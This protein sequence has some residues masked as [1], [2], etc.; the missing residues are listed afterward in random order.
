MAYTTD[1]LVTAIKRDSYLPAA[2]RDFGATNLLA[3]ADEALLETIA[4]A[5]V[6][7]DDG[8]FLEPADAS[9][10]ASTQDYQLDRY[11]MWSKLRRLQMLD[12]GG[13]L[14]TLRR[15][16]SEQAEV[17]DQDGTG[18]PES[19]LML[20]DKI[21]L[22][23]IPTGVETLRQWIYR[24]PG[25][26]VATT[27]AAQVSSVDS[28]TGIVTYTGSKPATF[29]SSSV[30]DFYK[31]SAPF[32]R[33]GTALSATA[34]PGANTQTFSTTNAA[35]LASGDWV[36]VRDETVFPALPVELHSFLK[37]LVIR[38]ITRTQG[39]RQ[40][41]E[42][43]RAEIRDRMIA[44]LQAGPGSRVVGHPKKLSIPLARVYPGLTVR[45]VRG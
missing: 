37:D 44:T 25:R 22:Y 27:A 6:S 28:G 36:C 12:S 13:S 33:V 10:V 30:H 29:T 8:F 15:L 38:S 42:T 2:Q 35:L 26:M 34:S 21:R 14:R 32:R 1:D 39:D 20:A 31:G 11:A 23:P 9:T 16:T 17:E 43:A 24:R 4:P 40:A 19:F 41:Y 7:H 5:L 18:N 3:V 45:R